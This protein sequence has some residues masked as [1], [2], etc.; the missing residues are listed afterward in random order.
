MSWEV[1]WNR[2]VA[3]LGRHDFLSWIEQMELL[4]RGRII[5]YWGLY[6][7]SQEEQSSIINVQGHSAC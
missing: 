6:R 5:M 4:V 1:G 7:S 2:S 3:I